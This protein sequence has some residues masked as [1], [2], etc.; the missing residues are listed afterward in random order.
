MLYE[1]AVAFPEVVTWFLGV[2]VR[3]QCTSAGKVN[4]LLDMPLPSKVPVS[5]AQK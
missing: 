5:G 2:F 3:N 1:K 4:T